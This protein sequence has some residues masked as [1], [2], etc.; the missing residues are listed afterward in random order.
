MAGRGESW[1]AG[2][3]GVVEAD[4]HAIERE[5]TGALGMWA[6]GSV[7][8]GT[9]LSLVGRMTHQPWLTGFANQ[10]VGWGAIDGAI[11]A[12]GAWKQRGQGPAGLAM[13]DHS[14][15]PDAKAMEQAARLHKL[16]RVNTALDVLYVAGG[17]AT[18]AASGT[19]ARRFGRDRGEV[20]GSGAGVIVQGGFLLVLDAFFARRVGRFISDI[21]ASGR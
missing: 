7:A 21:E 8:A 20:I 12:F 10:Q 9:G 3:M 11:A 4:T 16:L 14:D 1:C 17:V 6:T 13:V 15:R 5:L 18:I 19:L 2:L